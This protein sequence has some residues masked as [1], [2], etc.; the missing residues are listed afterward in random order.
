MIYTI[1]LYNAH[2]MTINPEDE[3]SESRGVHNAEAVRLPRNEW[4]GGI[5]V[6]PDC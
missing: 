1:N 5:L 2:I 3:H 6:E 4:Q